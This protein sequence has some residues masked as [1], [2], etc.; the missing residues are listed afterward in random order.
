MQIPRSRLLAAALAASLLCLSP[1]LAQE[2]V[3]RIAM[4]ASAVPTT[5]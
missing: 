5:T 1:A 2:K 3:L 4:T